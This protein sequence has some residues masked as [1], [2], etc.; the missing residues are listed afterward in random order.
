MS[1]LGRDVSQRPIVHPPSEITFRIA[2]VQCANARLCT[3][4]SAQVFVEFNVASWTLDNPV[5]LSTGTPLML[6]FI[7]RGPSS[8]RST[9]LCKKSVAAVQDRVDDLS[10]PSLSRLLLHLLVPWSCSLSSISASLFMPIFCR[11]CFCIST[12]SCV[13]SFPSSRAFF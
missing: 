11:D 6:S 8:S 4:L 3:A 10:A 2:H 1:K 5:L 13:T 12:I 7:S 9:G